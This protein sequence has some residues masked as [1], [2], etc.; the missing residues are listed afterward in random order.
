MF[1]YEFTTI[2]LWIVFL[3]I[4]TIITGNLWTFNQHFPPIATVLGILGT[5]MMI[6][7][8][9]AYFQVEP[10]SEVGTGNGRRITVPKVPAWFYL[11][12]LCH[13]ITW[14]ALWGSQN[15][16][17]DHHPIDLLVYEAQQRHQAYAQKSHSSKTLSQ[18]VQTYKDRYGRYPPPGFDAWYE[19][20]TARDSV[21]IDDYDSISR[22]LLP[23]YALSPAAIRER[24]WELVS[25]PWNDAASVHIRSGEVSLNPNMAAT[26]RWMTDGLSDMIQHF[27]KSLPDMDLAFNLNDECRV[28]VPFDEIE[29]L[30]RTGEPTRHPKIPYTGYSDNRAEQ[31][32]AIPEKSPTT[33]P[34]TEKSWQR[35]F[36]EF[37]NLGCPSNSAARTSR[38]WNVGE[39]CYSCTQPHSTGAFLSNWTLSGNIC[40]QPDLADLHGLYISPSAF[41]TTAELY[42]IFSQSKIHGFNDILYPSAWNY[43]DKAKYDPNAERTDPPFGQKNATLFWR[44]TTSEGFSSGRDQWQGMTRQRFIHLANDIPNTHP[45]PQAILLPEPITSRLGNLKYVSFPIRKLT[46]LFATDVHIVDAIARC[47][48]HDCEA[49]NVEF[50]PML[51]PTDFQD[52]WKYKYLLDLDGGGFSGRFLPFLHSRSLPFKAALFREW[53]EDRLTAWHHF[54]PLDVRGHGFWATLAWATGVHGTINGREVQIDAHARDA[55]RIAEQGREWAGKVLRKEDMEIYMF[56]LLLEWARLTDDRRDE[57]GFDVT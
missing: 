38:H 28:T 41:K 53:W 14:T 57:L 46:S 31:W 26:H 12:L 43:L 47:G 2:S 54:V 18:A 42:P 21:I 29:S 44:G 33:T 45:A 24:T 51:P 22:D 48:G 25:N 19:Y 55:E 49:Q 17:L 27:S 52:H 10:K 11:A 1:Q 15:G 7:G 13:F 3:S 9:G 30:R 4:S 36:Y 40:H 35:V 32:L 23:F 5:C 6:L 20:A 50:G 34:F 8:F 37:G 56:R 16:K 39:L